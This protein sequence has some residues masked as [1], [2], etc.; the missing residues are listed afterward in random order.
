MENEQSLEDQFL[1]VIYQNIEDNLGNERFSVEE[2][3]Q[4]VG[5]SRSTLHRKLIKLTGKS[6]SDLITEIRLTRAKE[7]LENN[8]ATASEIAYKVGFN[9]PSYFTKV[10]KNFYHV[11]PGDVRK[12]VVT[13]PDNQITGQ[14]DKSR[15]S[16]QNKFLIPLL[17]VL[18]IVL[19]FSAISTGVYYLFMVEAPSEKSIVVLPFDNLST[20]NETQY[21]ADGIAEDI[22]NNLYHFSD[23]RVIS[24]TTS[25]HYAG[26]NLTSREIAREVNTRYIL[27]GSVRRYGI[28]VR[29]STQL[30]D[31][32]T[33]E[34]VWSRTFDREL[35][36]II[37]V[38]GDI[39]LQVAKN[40]NAIISEKELN[41]LGNIHTN[42]PEA[43]DHYMRAR[44]LLH[45]ANSDQRS[46]FD[47]EGALACIKYFEKAL[48]LDTT[49]SEATAG[50]ANAWFVLAGWKM[51]PAYE[52]FSKAIILSKRALELDPNN[53]EAYAVK[54][55]YLVWA[56]RKFEE[57]RGELLT[58]IQLNPYFAT[59]H[60][61]Y[62][63]LLM[64]TG[65]IEESRMHV[66]ISAELEPY[67]WVVQ[68]L[69]AWIYYFEEKYEKSLEAAINARDLNPVFIQNKWLFFLNHV[70]LGEGEKA[71]KELQSIIHSTHEAEDMDNEIWDAYTKSGIK[72]LFL[73]LIQI[74]SR[75]PVPIDGLSGHPFFMA[76]WNVIIGNKEESIHWLQKNMEQKARLYY[77]FD[78]IAMNPDF[79]ILR[80]DPRFLAIMKELGLAPYHT[81]LEKV[82]SR[83][84]DM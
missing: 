29:I 14:S 72:G 39:A 57:G 24:R 6:A 10:F 23:L 79:D 5:L 51:V 41:K 4:N 30:I 67:F 12:G 40:L 78:L 15:L 13:I 60:Q 27:E 59:S 49:F 82:L 62:A 44:F 3:A 22:L 37:G 11:S 65:P 53:A 77:Y 21:F 73:W 9:S 64:I 1:D 35:E 43:Y 76:W 20:D 16:H 71:A 25:K 63:Q 47:K 66:N 55:A 7:L 54:G 61:W 19:S 83:K 68:N 36:N 81:R 75:I 58:S 8:V 50:L 70:K 34:H 2:L 28:K 31:A 32:H 46:G 48:T 74:N 45:K 42:N 84:R 17:F 38:Q 18:I 52:G 26:T 56:E 69:N 80:D 33:D